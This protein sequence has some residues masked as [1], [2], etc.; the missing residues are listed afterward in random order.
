MREN[1]R[2][3]RGIFIGQETEAMDILLC[4]AK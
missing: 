4:S 1:E 2:E 3:L